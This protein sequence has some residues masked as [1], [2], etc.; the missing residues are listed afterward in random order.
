MGLGCA[1]VSGDPA[2]VAT[3]PVAAV[4]PDSPAVAVLYFDY[5]GDDSELGSL[6]KGLAQMLISDMA[7]N[8][9][10][11]VVERAR[12]QDIL[13]ELQLSAGD[14]IDPDKAVQIGKLVGADLTIVGGYFEA[15]GVFR[16]DT[17]IVNTA[18]TMTTSRPA[19]T[20]RR[21][22]WAR[23]RPCLRFCS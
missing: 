1:G 11:Q 5:E 14:K 20:R 6:R 9:G 2:D 15:M 21:R 13:N 10:Y 17:R 18:A 4:V 22:A 19:A 16:V 12:L 7:S 23:R 8:Q 3:P